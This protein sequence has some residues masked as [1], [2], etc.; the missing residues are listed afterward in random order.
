[1]ASVPSQKEDFI[2]ISCGTWSLF[3]TELAQPVINEAIP[4]FQPHQRGGFGRTTRMLKNIWA[5]G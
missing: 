2:Y 1:M 4:G 5:C 3:G